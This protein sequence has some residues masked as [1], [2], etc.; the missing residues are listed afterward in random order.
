M[1]G[2]IE[3][4]PNGRA[5]VRIAS[6]EVDIAIDASH[7]GR[8]IDGDWVSIRTWQGKKRMM[9]EV[10]DVTERSRRRL[11]GTLSARPWHLECDDPRVLR[12]VRISDIG[13]AQAGDSVLVEIVGYPTDQDEEI[14][15]RV[16]GKLEPATML[17]TE[18]AKS[19][20]AHG[21]SEGYPDTVEN[22]VKTLSMP[23]EEVLLRDRIDVRHLPFVS[24]DPVSARDFDD[25]VCV[26][27]EDDGRFRVWVAI[28]DVAYFVAEESPV[29]LEARRR[30]TSVYLPDRAIPMLPEKLSSDLCSLLPQ[31]DRPAMV[32]EME[33]DR[34]GH[35]KH[36]E[37][38]GALIHSHGR[39][40][41]HGVAFVL[42]EGRGSGRYEHYAPHLDHLALLRD[43]ANLLRKQRHRRGSLDLDL[44]EAEILLDHDDPNRVRDVR[45][46]RVNPRVKEAYNL[47]E[48][49][50]L[51]AN[52]AVGSLFER[53][54]AATIWRIHPP[55]ALEDCEELAL[56]LASYGVTVDGHRLVGPRAMAKALREIAK[57]PASRPLSYQALR[58]LRQAS[59]HTKNKGHFGLASDCY[60]HFTSPIRRYPDLHVHRLLKQL[61]H[62]QGKPSGASSLVQ[63]SDRASLG[64][65]AFH[66][67]VQEREALEIERA[68]RGIYAATLMR[69]RIGDEME[70]IIVNAMP[71]GFFV[72]L[73]D[74]FVEGMVKIESLA[75][76]FQYDPLSLRFFSE[77]GTTVFSLGDAVL[78]RVIASNIAQRRV[79]FELIGHTATEPKPRRNTTHKGKKGSRDERENEK[80]NKK[81]QHKTGQHKTQGIRAFGEKMIR[82]KK[83]GKR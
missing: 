71:S 50:M 17:L 29:D 22:Q 69:D 23:M 34:E 73:E 65:I 52:E 15:G 51:V 16:I 3:F 6:H 62:V 64:E 14:E 33:I 75:Q 70:G 45:N 76:P 10:V 38:Y 68:V 32:V 58:S 63:R 43:V 47:I 66:A 19:L 37:A 9:G 11:T 41:Y 18:V 4:I 77:D 40:D 53:A 72:A 55:P 74:P 46:S 80:R 24:I 79:D 5:F 61:L 36:A 49:L 60:L 57:H 2:K 28:A 54:D 39:L 48:E 12:T 78:V 21:V 83:R 26:K 44:P 59:Y 7:V 27:C 42:E 30:S 13:M 67:S 20:V 56:L 1:I 8:A 35:L 81:G 31:Q 82:R 25:A